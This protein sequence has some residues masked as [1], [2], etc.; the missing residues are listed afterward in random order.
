[1]NDEGRYSPVT[2]SQGECHPVSTSIYFTLS[3]CTTAAEVVNYTKARWERVVTLAN[4]GETQWHFIST[5]ASP[6]FLSSHSSVGSQWPDPPRSS[7]SKH[8]H[9][10]THAGFLLICLWGL[11]IFCRHLQLKY[12][13]NNKSHP[14]IISDF[15]VTFKN[16]LVSGCAWIGFCQ[17]NS[18]IQ[19]QRQIIVDLLMSLWTFWRYVEWYD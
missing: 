17:C 6:P 11:A 16:C 3:F 7:V 10:Y 9:T 13:A 5:L 14:L 1:M 4:E 15:L 18:V 12:S 19:K 2:P 8:S